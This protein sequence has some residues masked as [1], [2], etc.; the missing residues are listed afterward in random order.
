[1][2]TFRR[3][4][5]V[6]VEPSAALLHAAKTR[7][8]KEVYYLAQ[9]GE[10]FETY[11]EYA[12]RLSFYK[13]KHFQCEVS[14]KSNLDYFQ[15]LDS[16]AQ[17]ART[18]HSRFPEQLKPA[19]LKA[20]QWQVMGRLDHLV[21][22][23]Y[24]RFKDRYFAGERV[25][26]EIQGD[27]FLARI[28][29]VFPP[30]PTSP[31]KN[32]YLPH[33]SPSMSRR[34][35][36][37]EERPCHVVL[38]DLK[39]PVKDADIDD[40]A[41]YIYKVQIIEEESG[42]GADSRSDK[43]LSAKERDAR[44]VNRQKWSGSIMEVR[45]NE[46]S[47]DRL[48]FSK[49][50]LRR[51]IRDCVDRDAAVASP[52]TVKPS[53]AERYGV[54]S[55]MPE[56][57]RKGVDAIKRKESDKRRK[58]FDDKEGPPSK[59]R[60]SEEG[61][62]AVPPLPVPS[63]V[64]V[65]EVKKEKKKPIR[66]PTEDLDIRL[67]DKEIKSGMKVRRP[68]PSRSTLPF[69]EDPAAFEGFLMSYNFLC[70][71]GQ[72]L[73]LSAFTLDDYEHALRH[74]LQHP[75][76]LIYEI[77]STLIYNLRTVPFE[78]HSAVVSLLNS[79]DAE[80]E[81]CLGVTID[82]LT[83]AMADIGN[84][85]E[86]VPLRHSEQREGW[87]DALVGCLKDHATTSDFPRLREILTRLL[88]APDISIDSP[89]SGESPS[90]ASS[91]PPTTL[92]VPSTP[93][94]R[95]HTLPPADKIAILS[96]M[97]GLAVSS[98]TIHAHMEA[99]EES[100]TAL[101]KEKIEVNRTK[102][103]LLEDMAT[104]LGEAQE[105]VESAEANGGEQSDHPPSASEESEA[106]ASRKKPKKKA[107]GGSAKQREAARAKMTA[108][109]QALAERRRLD[110]EVNKLERRLEGIEREFRKLFGAIRVKPMG[111]DRFYNRVWWFDGM[112]SASL[113]GSGG[114][115]QYGTGRVFVQG[116][117]EFDVLLLEKV[118]GDLAARR[119]DEEG[120]EGVLGV[121]QWAVYENVDEVEQFIAW[122]NPKG[123][124]ELAL[125]NAM[126]KW[127][128]HIAPGM[129]KRAADLETHAKLPDARRSQRKSGGIGE[130]GREPYMQWINRRASSGA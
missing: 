67:T 117:S 114:S 130:L 58:V 89:S 121:G 100:L 115:V 1:M 124:R 74:S 96:F 59:K 60:K 125:K 20:V 37:P 93:Q 104:L 39:I 15:A 85:W 66:Y 57:T 55:E 81:R 80:P 120:E 31:I 94:E 75:V 12:A 34:S 35:P 11:E 70:V 127:W 18:M 4:R 62:D 38:G 28:A 56:E 65:E 29:Q 110:E 41:A 128:T 33:K 88:F 25:L 97:C 123:V 23:V 32:N 36:G 14:G 19:I 8:E 69:G 27:K 17:E 91:P 101:R 113:L 48:S 21:E 53:I 30:R 49:S 44:E 10:I 77:H 22:A 105:V 111:R 92:S 78:R 26:V 84:N 122:L 119:R 52:W 43:K 82:Q 79:K 116:P 118:E 64:K 42:K 102:K 2:P 24:E 47:R 3:K 90:A 46:L 71:Y 73:H 16:E 109:K 7:P 98:K 83:A 95:Y 6:L 76:Q 103:Q 63:P 112:G 87:E 107:Q 129:R 54:S 126:T 51:F 9:T 108:A 50:I 106:V 45:C 61:P 86:R 72:I 68:T 13:L 5:V 99:C 40:P